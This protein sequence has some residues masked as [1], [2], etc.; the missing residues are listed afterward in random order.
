MIDIPYEQ[1]WFTVQYACGCCATH[2]EFRTPENELISRYS[3]DIYNSC[4]QCKIRD[5]QEKQRRIE[6]AAHVA[7]DRAARQL[8]QRMQP[9]KRYLV[10]GIPMVIKL[11]KDGMWRGKRQQQGKVIQKYF[12]RKDPRPLLVV[13]P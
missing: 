2:P 6:Q 3:E 1:I 10:D 5:E 12:G 11:S 9:T 13:A 4:K 7:A 8:E